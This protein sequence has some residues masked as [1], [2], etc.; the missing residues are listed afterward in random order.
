M[1]CDFS[2]RFSCRGWGVFSRQAFVF[3]TILVVA[4]G[5]GY[6]LALM[7]RAGTSPTLLNV[8]VALG[9]LTIGAIALP[10]LINVTASRSRNSNRQ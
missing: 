4:A 7:T 2:G 10:I 8:T 6:I 5:F 3:I 9:V 1:P